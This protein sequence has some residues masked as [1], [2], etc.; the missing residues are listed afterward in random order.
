[1]GSCA[2][3]ICLSSLSVVVG[4]LDLCGARGGPS[5]ADAP[6][7]VNADAVL[8]LAVAVQLLEAVTRWNPK[9]VD[10]LGGVEDQELAIGNS[11]KIGAE[12]ADV[13]A[14]PDEL[15]F[16]IRERLD[17]SKSITHGVTK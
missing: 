8:S 1:M 2:I 11:L 15:G 9:V 17:H 7:V 14:I 3:V 13:R 5:E 10:V 16:L 4:D 12:L 6:L